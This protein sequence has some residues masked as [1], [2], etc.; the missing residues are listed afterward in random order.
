LK[1]ILQ[2]TPGYTP[3][4]RTKE[5]VEACQV[6][7]G[8]PNT[9]AKVKQAAAGLKRKYAPQPEDTTQASTSRG[10]LTFE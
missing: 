5:M 9:K 1:R 6:I 2:D 7:N 10:R 3:L 8:Q 4:Q